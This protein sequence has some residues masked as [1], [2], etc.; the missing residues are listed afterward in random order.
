[1]AK[2][3]ELIDAA[4]NRTGDNGS[5]TLIIANHLAQMRS[6]GIR[7]G[8]QFF[9]V[10]DD[11]RKTREIFVNKV[12]SLNKLDLI[13]HRLWDILLCRGRLLLY[14]RP[15]D[16]G[17]YRVSWFPKQQFEAY[18]SP[19]GELEEVSIVYTY[20]TKVP[21]AQSPTGDSF[22]AA[23]KRWVRLK[24]TKDEIESYESDI[25]L[26]AG[27]DYTANLTGV[28][29]FPNTLGWIPCLVVNNY[30]LSDEN[31]SADD[32]TWLKN[33]IE[34]QD[35][36]ERAVAENLNFFGNQTLVATRSIGELTDAG[37]VDSRS[38]ISSFSNFYS[39]GQM[40][41]S[42]RFT[43]NASSIDTVRIKKVIS[44][45][46]PEERFG[47][48]SPDPVTGDHNLYL[49][50]RR[51]AIRTALGGV[52]ELGISSGATAFEVKSLFGRAAAT[53]RNKAQ[54][55]YDYGICKIIEMAI[56]AEEE[57]WKKSVE[58]II[59]GEEGA[60]ILAAVYP[61][62]P[63]TAIKA[64]LKSLKDGQP[65]SD[66]VFQAIHDSGMPLNTEG[67][68]PLGDRTID[69]RWT[70]PVFE[71]SSQDLLNKSI[72]ARNMAEDGVG[73]EYCLKHLYPDKTT[74][75]IDEM[76]GSNTSIPFRRLQQTSG[77]LGQILSLW[78]QIGQSPHP[79]NPGMPMSQD[80]AFSMPVYEASTNILK[81]MSIDV[82]R[83]RQ[84]DPVE[85]SSIPS[86]API[87][88]APN[89]SEVPG[90]I[91][92]R[93]SYYDANVGTRPDAGWSGANS[94]AAY[95]GTAPSS[96][97]VPDEFGQS[98]ATSVPGFDIG[99][100]YPS[101]GQLPIPGVFTKRSE[102]RQPGVLPSQQP[103]VSTNTDLFGVPSDI[104]A[105]PSLLQQ[106]FPT[107]SQLLPAK[108]SKKAS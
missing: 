87:T 54:N 81:K 69:W 79:Q 19:E 82:G 18:Y 33:Q 17:N 36:L 26:K 100:Q 103:G 3:E 51:E 64:I 52:D 74:K 7:Q 104:A 38:T 55:L 1:M 57:I 15:T 12:I 73:R 41:S 31:E 66:D 27:E 106:L 25:E 40:P 53:A 48:I 85:A 29:K 67:L 105:N 101:L 97:P 37:V 102:L 46:Q 94:A 5:E 9:P 80:P 98:V 8:V 43:R 83:V 76:V 14:M 56:Q 11:D 59:A 42:S 107:F 16:D 50:E 62:A 39:A 22:A 23:K 4:L 70:G 75:E 65:L 84:I 45:V 90:D 24:I 21:L 93:I 89:E 68:P 63:K 32:F 88:N 60:D 72:V 99:T 35:D 71:E 58:A 13:L 86:P 95:F 108:R 20:K 28:Q 6:F 61:E 47:Y 30:F 2:L 78:G 34:R 77:A 96:A 92:G 44:G 10:Q 49:K 91:D